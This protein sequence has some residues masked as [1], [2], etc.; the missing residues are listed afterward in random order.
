MKHKVTDTEKADTD[1]RYQMK[2]EIKSTHLPKLTTS[3][4]YILTLL[5]I[6]V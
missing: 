6:T 1:H 3:I 4:R 5:K 2:N